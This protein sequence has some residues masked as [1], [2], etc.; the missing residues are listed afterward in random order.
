[1][2]KIVILFLVWRALLFIVAGVSPIFIDQFGARF[3]YYQERLIDT[4]L[5]HFIWSF[6]NFDG[7]HYLGIAKDAYAAQYTQAFF[8]F[9]PILIK[10]V[11]FLTF[12]NLLVSA[13]LI[14]NIFFLAALLIFYKLVSKTHNQKI[15]FWSILFLLS[16]PTSFF[17]GAVY[18]ESV[19]F[20]LIVSAFYL[21]E[22]GKIWQASLLGL[23][24]SGTRLVGIFLV[25]ALLFKKD[26][27]HIFPLLAVP[28]GLISYMIFLGVKFNDPFYF[29]TSQ[30][31]FGQERLSNGIVLLPQV[32]FRYFKILITTHGLPLVNAAF[33]L[34]ATVWVGAALAMAFKKVKL[35]WLIFS[36]LVVITPTLTGT[37]ASMPRYILIAFPIYL[38][39]AYIKSTKIKIMLIAA[40]LAILAIAETFFTQG[41]WVA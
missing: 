17:F 4:K 39:P 24:A 30:Q 9:Y 41:Y 6:G 12:G 28:L 34:L 16:F 38:V 32:F 33:E 31:I 11:S 35:E 2:K 5:P 15:A 25:P 7:V 19:F 3:P 40:S 21:A 22:K 26:K 14:S 10:A 1:M 13:L 29:L 23:L 20:L 37:L 18:T 8:P 27:R 36:F